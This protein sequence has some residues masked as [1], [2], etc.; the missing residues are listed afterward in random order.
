MFSASGQ[1]PSP[2]VLETGFLQA[3]AFSWSLAFSSICDW[4]L[5]TITALVIEA[6]LVPDLH[7]SE[8]CKRQELHLNC[9]WRLGLSAFWILR[10][11]WPLPEAKCPAC[12][13]LS[14]GQ[15]AFLFPVAGTV[16]SPLTVPGLC[17]ISGPG[18]LETVGQSL[19]T[20]SWCVVGLTGIICN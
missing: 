6:S 12:C 16:C 8:F 20:Y 1:P 4:D 3:S 14:V 19:I 11:P 2:L 5:L 7:I 17:L 13:V 15:E 10:L 18:I 9:L